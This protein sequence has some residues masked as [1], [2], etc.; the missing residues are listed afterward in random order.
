MRCPFCQYNDSRVVDSRE[1]DDGDAVRRRRVCPECNRRFTTYERYESAGLIVI[2]KDGRR[3]EFKPEK[4]RQKIRVALTKRPIGEDAID[5]LVNRVEGQLLAEGTREVPSMKVG[6]L[7][8]EELR[9]LDKVAYVRFASVYFQY[10]DLDELQRA[11]ESLR[12]RQ[13]A[14]GLGTETRSHSE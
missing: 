6:E 10:S 3:E 7:V 5:A 8:L 1:L 11:V 14:A 2:K 13:G 9:E 12:D 4:L